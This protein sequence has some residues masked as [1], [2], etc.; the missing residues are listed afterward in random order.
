MFA[1]L[2]EMS[3]KPEK[4]SEF[5]NTIRQEI[6]PLLRKYDGFLD[7]IQLQVEA[8]P[9]KMYAITFWNDKKDAEKYETENFTKVAAAYEPFL[10]KPALVKLCT[11]DE[12]IFSRVITV[13]A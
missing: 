7:V 5:L 12:T 6:V 1:R 10:A 4:K 11:V 8:D 13:A 2:L 9:T 3:V